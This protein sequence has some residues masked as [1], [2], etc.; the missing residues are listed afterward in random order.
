VTSETLI[1]TK[2]AA[3]KG[4]MNERM[5]RLW[6]GAEAEEIGRGSLAMVQFGVTPPSVHNMIVGLERRGLI[7]RVPR[8]PRSIEVDIPASAPTDQVLWRGTSAPLSISDQAFGDRSVPVTEVHAK[9]EV[10]EAI[11]LAQRIDDGDLF[12]PSQLVSNALQ[13]IRRKGRPILDYNAVDIAYLDE[14]AAGGDLDKCSQSTQS[15]VLTVHHALLPLD[16]ASARLHRP[17]DCLVHHLRR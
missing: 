7:R 12:V 13:H 2:F 14:V 4:S 9:G 6:A 17:D 11:V 1:R 8:Q 16:V 3:L 10:D 15:N 5:T